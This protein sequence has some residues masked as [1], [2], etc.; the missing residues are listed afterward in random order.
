MISLSNDGIKDRSRGWGFDRT[1]DDACVTAGR[2]PGCGGLEKDRWMDVGRG[3]GKAGTNRDP[4]SEVRG[5]SN[6]VESGA[7]YHGRK[8]EEER[9]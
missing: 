5:S 9:A 4:D 8:I 1:T 3:W 6:W 7:V 2:K